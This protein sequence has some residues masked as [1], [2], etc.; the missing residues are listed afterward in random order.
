MTLLF[1]PQLL[2]FL[3]SLLVLSSWLNTILTRRFHFSNK[4][5][6]QFAWGW[7]VYFLIYI[8]GCQI[9]APVEAIRFLFTGMALGVPIIAGIWKILGRPEIL[10]A[11]AF[12]RTI[13]KDK[14]AFILAVLF[15]G[16]MGYI[17]PYLEFPSDPLFHLESIQAWE[18][19]RWMDGSRGRATHFAYFL[20]HWLLQPTQISL[21]DRSGLAV[22]CAVLQ[23]ML[24][25]NFIRFTRFFTNNTWVGCFGGVASIGLFGFNIFSFY[26][27]YVLADT[28][29]AYLVL[30]EA[31]GLM[32]CYFFKER[33]RYLFLMLP[34]MVFCW[35][36][37]R[38]EVLLLLNGG[39]GVGV[40]LLLFRYKCLSRSFRIQ[41][42]VLI[43]LSLSGMVVVLVFF[44]SPPHLFQEL[45]LQQVMEGIFKRP[46]Y[47]ISFSRLNDALGLGGW[48]AVISSLG[49]L[50]G[51]Q[52]K[53][54][55]ILAAMCLWPL[56]VLWNPLAVAVLHKAIP[57]DVLYRLVY[58]SMYWIFLVIFVEHLYG[59]RYLLFGQMSWP[60]LAH[61]N[62]PYHF[63]QLGLIVVLSLLLLGTSLISQSPIRGKIPHLLTKADAHL[64]GKDLEPM[65]RYLRQTSPSHCID[66]YLEETHFPLRSFILSNS[67]INSYLLMTGYFYTISNRWG[68]QEPFKLLEEL[69]MLIRAG[70][71]TD[72]KTF[73]EVLKKQHICY[74]VLSTNDSVSNSPLGR[75][76]GHWPPDYVKSQHRHSKKL[77][78]WIKEYSQH[79]QLVFQDT[80]V[81]VYQVL[82]GN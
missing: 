67:Y 64:N 19:L 18:T 30:L 27:Y 70:K 54:L 3:I 11:P 23:G 7:C 13:L 71:E 58:G 68:M 62:L 57:S 77:H 46:F 22:L 73:P 4:F 74:V 66:P 41:W 10:Q 21:G 44:P 38:Q 76:S 78:Q 26:R 36:N 81:Q 5:L 14:G 43:G 42:T 33:S 2:G 25:W 24:L 59:Y 75:L 17:G 37:H 15:G 65:I 82:P 8:L 34:L 80:A 45:Y 50:L 53:K 40:L 6:P 56:L 12:S 49:I 52:A 60:L 9:S 61:S 28:F 35:Q 20:H 39:I 29:I 69:K 48:L 72:L 32:C 31:F 16:G 55:A 63:R 47:V 1:I 51:S 79:F